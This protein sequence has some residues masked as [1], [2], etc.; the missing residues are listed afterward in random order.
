M[1]VQQQQLIR[2]AD[3]V[4]TTVPVGEGSATS[5]PSEAIVPSAALSVMVMHPILFY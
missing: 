2:N 1:I 4:V 5:G 3:S